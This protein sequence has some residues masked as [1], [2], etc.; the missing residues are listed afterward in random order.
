MS[1]VP[2]EAQPN[3]FQTRVIDRL[4]ELHRDPFE[5]ARIGEF[6]DRRFVYDI[7]ILRKQSVRGTNLAKLAKGL[8]WTTAEL[9]TEPGAEASAPQSRDLPPPDVSLPR[10]GQEKLVKLPEI[11]N[12]DVEVKG[13][14]V[15][16]DGADFRF[17]GETIDRISRPP[18]ITH[19]QG[20]FAIY[21]EAESMYPAF[22]PGDP[23]YID[24]NRQPRIGDDVVVELHGRDG[25][26][27][28]AFV[29]RLVRRSASKV[30]VEQF[31]PS[32][33]IE[34]DATKVVRLL[35]VIPW[36]ELVG[37]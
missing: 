37:A 31:N 28:D 5:A 14:G 23:L 26:P 30:V 10:P 22:R 3:E 20:V 7:T 8:D 13:I 33:E 11:G 18:G 9:M 36:V 29:K 32:K 1:K 17:N 35:R 19:K 24:P 16:G 6:T 34:F 27:G 21:L 4:R 12:R 2:T 25:E 15:G